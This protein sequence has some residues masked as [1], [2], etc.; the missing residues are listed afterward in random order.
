MG[1][2]NFIFNKIKKYLIKSKKTFV[3]KI[4]I[5][6]YIIVNVIQDI[7]TIKK[8]MLRLYEKNSIFTRVASYL[9]I[10]YCL[11]FYSITNML[12]IRKF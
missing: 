8:F 3:K 2:F 4:Q 12:A 7:H 11:V 1:S 5:R 9:E 6:Y 10:A